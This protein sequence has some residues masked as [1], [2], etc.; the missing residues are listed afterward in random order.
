MLALSLL[1]AAVALL[2]ARAAAYT[3]TSV[4][5]HAGAYGGTS[6]AVSDGTGTA[7]TFAYPAWITMGP[8]GDLWVADANSAIIRT[9]DDAGLVTTVAGKD[10]LG[11][12]AF[13]QVD[14]NGDN[15]RLGV[16]SGITYSGGD[17]WFYDMDPFTGNMSLRTV[18]SSFNVD[19]QQAVG[20]WSGGGYGLSR[21][22]TSGTSYFMKVDYGSSNTLESFDSGSNASTLLSTGGPGDTVLDGNG[23]LIVA[24]AANHV[25]KSVDLSTGTP[26]TV[27]GLSGTSGSA[28]GT[29]GA[30]RFNLPYGITLDPNGDLIVADTLNGLIRR[31]DLGTGVVETI[32][33]LGT[34]GAPGTFSFPTDVAVNSSGDIF[35][36]DIGTNQILVMR[37]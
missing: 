35:I 28:D 36:T 16:V 4:T 24:D 2:P 18:D 11:G 7:A 22:D 10:R 34:S 30:A 12:G 27:A 19:T 14:A 3:Y 31:V 26:T 5:V 21:D 9:V 29:G 8:G 17:I 25:I 6:G 13:G 20:N 37:A 1:L 32:A 15:A 23:N 33:G